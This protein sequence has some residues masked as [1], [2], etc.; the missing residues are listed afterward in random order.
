[1]SAVRVSETC[2]SN[3]LDAEYYQPHYREL[4]NRLILANAIPVQEFAYVTDGIHGSPDWADEDGVAYLLAKC[5]KENHLVLTEAGQISH[6]QHTS[7]PRTQAHL[8]DVLLTCIGTIGAAAVVSQEVLP[9]SVDRNLG[10]IRIREDR[11]D[12]YY[13]ATFFN[14]AYGRFQTSREAT[15]NVQPALFIEKMKTLLV[16]YGDRFN[17]V[18]KKTRQAYQKYRESENLYAQAQALLAAELGLDKLDL[19]ESLFSVRR[20]SEVVEA[21]RADAEYFQPKYDRIMAALERS[22]WCIGDVATLAKRRFEPQLSQPFNYIEINDLSGEGYAES[23]IIHGEDAPSRAQWIVFTGDVITS[24]VRPIRRLSAVVE[25][26][27]RGSVCSSG[28]AVLQPKSVEPELLL[29][30]LRLPIVCEILDLYTTA[31]MYPAIST[32]DLLGIPI[33]LPQSDAVRK[34][35]VDKVQDSRQARRVAKRLLAEAKAEVE[36]IIGEGNT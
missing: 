20:V 12:P 31:S 4:L 10:I 33:T 35:L 8:N 5:V 26:E 32:I 23:Q 29:L 18:G 28:F 6:E 25:R 15:G 1:V 22:G 19:S 24:T 9:A 34:E 2:S 16:P 13:L 3:R 14:C 36:R 7:D 11:V 17:E 21:G 30:Y 27:Q